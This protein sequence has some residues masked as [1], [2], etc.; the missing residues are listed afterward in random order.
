MDLQG[1][2]DDSHLDMVFS[3]LKDSVAGTESYGLSDA[4]VYMFGVLGS[5]SLSYAERV[6]GVEGFFK[7]VGSAAVKVWEYIKSMLKGIKDFFFGGSKGE[8][9]K[10]TTDKAKEEVN[11]NKSE[12]G[13]DF[14]ESKHDMLKARQLAL[15]SHYDRYV[16]RAQS[17][18]EVQKGGDGKEHKSSKMLS[19]L[20]VEFE[21]S[22]KTTQT[23]IDS[24]CNKPITSANDAKNTQ[25]K[26]LALIKCLDA[27]REMVERHKSGFDSGVSDLE[28]KLEHTTDELDQMVLGYELTAVK[29]MTNIFVKI[30]QHLKTAA[31]DVTK[32]SDALKLATK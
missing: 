8:S 17:S 30:G 6:T 32:L 1:F 15:K 23:I 12:M 10:A 14:D 3:A 5:E 11:S 27:D 26:L 31:E 28:K 16:N 22:V 29:G 9:A 2:P 19:G 20:R 25:D 4:Q 7:N 13:S 21:H 18:L 24:I